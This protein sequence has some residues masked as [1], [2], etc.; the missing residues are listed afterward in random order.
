V[1]Q[2]HA[3]WDLSTTWSW[4]ASF[5]LQSLYTLGKSTWYPLDR[6]LG[7]LRHSLDTVVKRKIT[8]PCQDL[9][10]WSSSL[11][12]IAIL[13]PCKPSQAVENKIGFVACSPTL[14]LHTDT[15]HQ[16]VKT[17]KKTGKMTQQ[18]KT[19]FHT[20]QRVLI[21]KK[22]EG[23]SMTTTHFQTVIIFTVWFKSHLN[24]ITKWILLIT[25]LS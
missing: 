11:Q 17:R 1:V 2:L 3:F 16:P 4:V 14:F 12:T 25:F 9:N 20:P 18:T 10:T 21:W 24:G 22:V 23:V 5:M 6:R 7:G 19:F 13:T 15:L 8:S